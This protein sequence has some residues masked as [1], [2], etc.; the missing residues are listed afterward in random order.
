MSIGVSSAC[1]AGRPSTKGAVRTEQRHQLSTGLPASSRQRQ[2]SAHTI[3]RGVAASVSPVERQLASSPQQDASTAGQ[4]ASRDSNSR[5]D[6]PPACTARHCLHRNFRHGWAPQK[7]TACERSC[8][9]LLNRNVGYP[10]S[11][12]CKT[13]ENLLVMS[14]RTR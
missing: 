5:R 14:R 9:R 6:A 12:A 10:M 4:R 1:T 3:D 11:W 13:R 8:P 7:R 2:P